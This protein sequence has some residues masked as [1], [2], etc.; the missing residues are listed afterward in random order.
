MSSSMDTHLA[1]AL[2]NQ[3]TFIGTN[4]INTDRHEMS[5]DVLFSNYVC[6]I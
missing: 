1:A 5:Q 6:I 4:A 3:I 2:D